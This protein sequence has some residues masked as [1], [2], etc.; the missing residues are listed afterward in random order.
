M[1]LSFYLISTLSYLVLGCWLAWR[2]AAKSAPNTPLH[3]YPGI[4]AIIPVKGPAPRLPEVVLSLDRQHYPG[5]IEI[6][7]VFQD[8]EDPELE[9]AERLKHHLQSPLTILKGAPRV[10]ANPKNSNLFHGIRAARHPWIYCCDADTTAPPE[11]LKDLMEKCEASPMRYGT[12]ISIHSGSKEMGAHLE[13]VATNFEFLLYFL[14]SYRFGGGPIN[15]AAMFFS[16]DLLEKVGGMKETLDKLTDDLVLTRLFRAAGAQG[17]LSRYA[18]NVEL[19]EEPMSGFFRRYQRW[20]LIVRCYAP[21]LFWMAPMN[22]IPQALV[23]SGIMTNWMEGLA[24]GSLILAARMMSSALIQI[25]HARPGEWKKSAVFALYD[26]W[27]PFIWVSTLFVRKV[28]WAGK[29]L[30]IGRAG[31]LKTSPHPLS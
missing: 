4:S 30:Q 3:R 2:W 1:L 8:A 10:G 7:L 28:N 27:V 17:H 19:P 5:E 24:V 26:A 21:H 15:G 12:A 23:L 25:L 29:E 31:I 20:M 14:V 18:V 11:M 13:T 22:F 9:I 16:R 6:V